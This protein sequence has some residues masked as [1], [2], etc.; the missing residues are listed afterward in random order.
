MHWF[1]YFILKD[2]SG[3]SIDILPQ[4]GSECAIV[5]VKK[6]HMS[7]DPFLE[8]RIIQPIFRR[9]VLLVQVVNFK[10]LKDS[11]CKFIYQADHIAIFHSICLITLMKSYTS[12]RI[13][14]ILNHFWKCDLKWWNMMSELIT[15]FLCVIY[16][17]DW[18]GLVIL[19][20]Y[21]WKFVIICDHLV[22][23][24]T[25]FEENLF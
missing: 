9:E 17:Y 15:L 16:L 21:I 23:E 22:N 5:W 20:C 13:D 4:S 7:L 12:S 14:I 18:S 1:L 25:I 24:Y 11:S 8:S 2:V 6:C 3:F 10:F 19:F